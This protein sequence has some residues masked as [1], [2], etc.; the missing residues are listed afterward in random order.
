MSQRPTSLW[1]GTV[2]HERDAEMLLDE[3]GVLFWKVEDDYWDGP[4]A[5]GEFFAYFDPNSEEEH[6][7]VLAIIEAYEEDGDA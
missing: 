3:D 7:E 6:V 2:T 4:N 5:A 1:K